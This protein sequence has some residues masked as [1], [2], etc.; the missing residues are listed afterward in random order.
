MG[1]GWG[2]VGGPGS[3]ERGLQL[4]PEIMKLMTSLFNPCEFV[5]IV[6]FHK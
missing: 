1:V 6:H 2:E 5:T 4:R 3:F